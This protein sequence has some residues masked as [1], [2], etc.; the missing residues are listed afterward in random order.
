MTAAEFEAYVT[1]RTLFF[2]QNGQVYGAEEY[3]DNRRVRWSFLDGECK[4][5]IWYEEGDQIC[6]VYEDRLV[7]QCWQFFL[8]GTGLTAQFEGDPDQPELYEARELDE[9]MICLGPEVGV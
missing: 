8:D 9:E 7:P 4:E 1:G 3:R 2:G 5:G 6:F